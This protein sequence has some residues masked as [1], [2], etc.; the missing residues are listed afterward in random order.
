[1][2]VGNV[3]GRSFRCDLHNF[4]HQLLH[5]S[6]GKLSFPYLPNPDTFLTY[7]C[8]LL[9]PLVSMASNYL[10]PARKESLANTLW[11][12][13]CWPH[14]WLQRTHCTV[15]Y[16]L[17]RFALQDNFWEAPSEPHVKPTTFFFF[18]PTNGVW[19]YAHL[20]FI[21]FQIGLYLCGISGSSTCKSAVSFQKYYVLK[22][23][24]W[25]FFDARQNWV[26]SLCTVQ[27][28]CSIVYQVMSI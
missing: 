12:D 15:I 10:V 16:R 21:L 1:M 14:T 6:D 24:I 4:K 23:V 3:V 5:Y 2:Q 22:C 7:L 20:F 8:H 28:L 9:P 13:F 25:I 26:N 27:K 17:Q 11:L 19:R 18:S